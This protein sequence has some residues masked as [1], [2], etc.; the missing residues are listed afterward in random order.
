MK[1]RAT[2]ELLAPL[3]DVW[4]FLAEPHNLAGWWPG[5]GGVQPDRRGFAP[6]ARWQVTRG[7]TPGLIRGPAYTTALLVTEIEPMR[8]FVFHLTDE[9][10]L[11]ELELED[12][13]GGRTRAELTIQSPFLLGFR[14]NLARQALGR[15]HALLRTAERG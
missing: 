2:R 10:T 7:P 5:I 8:R 12:G 9:R 11:A 1:V 14:R 15:L 6:G 4:S 13:G 3:E